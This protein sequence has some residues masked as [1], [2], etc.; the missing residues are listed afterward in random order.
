[1]DMRRPTCAQMSALALLLGCLLGSS[2]LARDDVILAK[3]GLD[4]LSK[5]QQ[6]QL[7]RRV[8]VYADMESFANFCGR[9]SQIERRVVSAVRPCIAPA[10]LQQVVGFFRKKLTE[11]N[12]RITADP[13]ICE[14]PRI[15]NLVKEIHSS[16]DKLVAEVARMCKSC[17]IC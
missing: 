7:W 4:W 3:V 8:E 10:S 16:I 15:K 6:Q 13:T 12:E 5:E 17:F 1:M 11:K 9:P 14:E 2:A